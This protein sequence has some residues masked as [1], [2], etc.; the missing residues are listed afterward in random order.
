[1][2]KDLEKVM[3]IITENREKTGDCM[4]RTEDDNGISYC[5]S[6]M[7][8]CPYINIYKITFTTRRDENGTYLQ[9]FYHC[10]YKKE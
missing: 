3:K 4:C 7:V 8:D 9:K 10:N 1:M 2:E 6:M 5:A